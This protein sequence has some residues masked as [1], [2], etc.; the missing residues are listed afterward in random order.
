MKRIILIFLVLIIF[1]TSCSN[2]IGLFDRCPKSCDDS[3][4]CTNDVCSKE[5]NYV[6]VNQKITPCDG[7]GICEKGEFET[8]LDCPK[9]DDQNICTD[10][11][12]DFDSQKCINNDITKSKS[13]QYSNDD[14]RDYLGPLSYALVNGDKRTV[15]CFFDAKL[16]DDEIARFIDIN[17]DFSVYLFPVSSWTPNNIVT[18]WVSDPNF[19]THKVEFYMR[20]YD[21]KWRIVKIVDNDNILKS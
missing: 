21:D 7:N 8:S 1:L 12:Y 20:K 15:K 14:P 18:S 19:K 2:K 9:C 17:K 10:D 5:T 6:C 16:S 3:N 11:S 13:V 4:S